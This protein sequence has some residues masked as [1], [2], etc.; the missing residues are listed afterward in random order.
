MNR[1][2]LGAPV[3]L[4]GCWVE[5][6]LDAETDVGQWL[7]LT[8][9]T[10][11]ARA[12][13]PSGAV[14]DPAVRGAWSAAIGQARDRAAHEVLQHA[15]VGAVAWT[16]PGASRPVAVL[17]VAAL[18][19][20]EV[21]ML[22]IAEELD[23]LFA[24]VRDEAVDPSAGSQGLSA[25]GGGVLRMAA[26]AAGG[27]PPGED[28]PYVLGYAWQQP[29][30]G[31]LAAVGV[32]AVGNDTDALAHLDAYDDMVTTLELR[33]VPER[34]MSIRLFSTLAEQWSAEPATSPPG[35]TP[36]ATWQP[37]PPP[38][39]PVPVRR[40]WPDRLSALG[41]SLRAPALIGAVLGLVAIV[42]SLATGMDSDASLVL[43]GGSLIGG[44]CFG[45][46]GLLFCAVS[47]SMDL[48][49]R[50]AAGD[51]ADMWV[52]YVITAL[53]LALTV[54]FVI[55]SAYLLVRG[56]QLF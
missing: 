18:R 43:W 54:M 8:L 21:P 37:P 51:G 53:G 13:W 44:A 36:A 12:Q 42:V 32:V 7:F 52:L 49:L 41:G 15:M 45:A 39:A 25:V 50:P 17:D 11:A 1:L 16:P 4:D 48:N 38:L 20:P 29:G 33:G 10:V 34:T 3:S 31:C 28:L 27:W 19:L 40:A 6:P 22:G 56:E 46:L 30:R 14:D 2:P 47:L 5:L 35:P 26:P 9:P 55:F 24:E 23:R